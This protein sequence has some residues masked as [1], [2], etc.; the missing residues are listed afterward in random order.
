MK[1]KM[2]LLAMLLG[3]ALLAGCAG[4]KETDMGG[5]PMDINTFSFYHTAS[6]SGEC[7]RFELSR[8]ETGVCLYAEE[9]FLSGRIA[10]ATVEEDLLA[11]L[12]EI[13]G[14]LGVAKWDG[15]DKTNKRGSD[16]STFTL[17]IT[18][19]DGSSVSAHGS[20]RFPD[21]YNELY[22]AVREMYNELME[23]YGISGE[24]GEAP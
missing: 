23:Q 3:L 7:F 20:N 18:L 2:I 24:G 19:A 6:E 14:E 1:Y 15:F 21:N 5:I 9:L 16:G 12:G 8:A 17:S 22:S 10:E 4:N 13:A 11:R